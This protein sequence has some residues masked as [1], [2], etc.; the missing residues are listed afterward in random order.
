MSTYYKWTFYKSYIV[1]NHTWNL[2][3][4]VKLLEIQSLMFKDK[5]SFQS[6]TCAAAIDWDQVNI[7]YVLLLLLPL[8][9]FIFS[10]LHLLC[11]LHLHLLGHLHVLGHTGELKAHGDGAFRPRTCQAPWLE[12]TTYNLAK[13]KTLYTWVGSLIRAS[14]SNFESG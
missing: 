6:S 1:S 3:L 7:L 13:A 8:N 11:H 4:D 9:S 12:K 10:L 2:V 5:T 14:V